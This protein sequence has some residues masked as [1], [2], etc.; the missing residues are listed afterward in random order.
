VGRLYNIDDVLYVFDNPQKRDTDVRISP[1]QFLRN[2]EFGIRDEKHGIVI[3]EPV[4]DWSLLARQKVYSRLR[5]KC[6]EDDEYEKR[7]W[8]NRNVIKDDYY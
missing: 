8:W 5:D 3:K 4:S 1:V 6:Y 7:H 2:R